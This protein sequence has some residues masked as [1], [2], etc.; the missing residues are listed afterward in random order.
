MN[1]IIIDDDKL[2][3]RVIE[4]FINKTD[5]LKLVGSFKNAI[6]AINTISKD[7]NI[8]LI[9]LDI[10]MPEMNG[11]DFLNSMKVPLQVIIISSKEKYAIE[12]FDYDV[13]D[14]LLKP[15]AYSRFYKAVTKALK[16]QDQTKQDADDKGEI[17]IK[18]G[19]SL[20]RIKFDNILW[21]E[22]LEN[23]VIL[24]TINDRMTIHFT[25]KA[26]E[27]K[28]PANKFTRIHRSFIVNVNK[29]S[30]IQDNFVE[31]KSQNVTKNIPI[32]KSFK[33]QLLRDI[34]LMIK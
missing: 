27:K 7:V 1:C 10:E 29:I 4:E 22:A 24:N 30:V 19:S 33:D 20:V 21:V 9:F 25:M 13:T 16:R 11:I 34:N 8:Q 18:K 3:R 32:G 6:D 5:E 23:Y 28:L 2:S 12:A 26:I 31:I 15:I 14:Y 17:F